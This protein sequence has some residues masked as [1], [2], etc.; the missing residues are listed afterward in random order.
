[1]IVEPVSI[2]KTELLE[3][4]NKIQNWI[5]DKKIVLPCPFSL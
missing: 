4:S 2:Q 3:K 1:M 5:I